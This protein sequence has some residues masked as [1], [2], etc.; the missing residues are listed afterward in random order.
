[1]E[2]DG[3]VSFSPSPLWGGWPDEVGSGGGLLTQ[4]PPPSLS[5]DLAKG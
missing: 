5:T 4:Y 3:F 2:S 1:M